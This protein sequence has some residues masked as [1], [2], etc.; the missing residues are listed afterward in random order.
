MYHAESSCLFEIDATELPAL[1]DTIDGQL[2]SDVT[3]VPKYETAFR[4]GHPPP[5][6]PPPPNTQP[7]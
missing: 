6:L 2:C 4:F 3:G 7:A 5:D 1:L